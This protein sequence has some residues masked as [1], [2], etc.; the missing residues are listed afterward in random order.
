MIAGS[1]RRATNLLGRHS[2]TG[3][4]L[5]WTFRRSMT[6]VVLPR[7]TSKDELMETA[8]MTSKGQLVIP[9]RIRDAVRAKA[10]TVFAVRTEGARI[11]LEIPK[12]QEKSVADWPGLNPRGLRLSTSELCEPVMLVD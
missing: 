5:F 11:V 1:R 7:L 8:K 12:G 3:D 10:G 2:L 4:K 9:K 6:R